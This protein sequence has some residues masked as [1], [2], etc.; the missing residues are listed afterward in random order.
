MRK[1]ET[2]ILLT[3]GEQEIIVGL[4]DTALA[5]EIADK[6]PLCTVMEEFGGREYCGEELPFVP[7]NKQENQTYFDIGD[8]VYWGKGN[9]LAFFYAEGDSKAVPSGVAVIGKILSDLSELKIMPTQ[10]KVTLSKQ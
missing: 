6:L 9:A 8:F 10:I 7:E 3:V 4:Y 2:K 5:R 1:I